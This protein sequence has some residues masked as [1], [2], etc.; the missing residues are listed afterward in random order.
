MVL[1]LRVAMN[2]WLEKRGGEAVLFVRRSQAPPHGTGA[3]NLCEAG[4]GRQREWFP[5][6]AETKGVDR[7]GETGLG[8]AED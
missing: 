2:K 7:Q 3:R 8:G 5:P 4:A 1:I 6:F